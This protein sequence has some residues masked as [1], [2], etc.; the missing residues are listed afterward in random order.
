MTANGNGRF[1]GGDLYDNNMTLFLLD[2]VDSCFDAMDM[3]RFAFCSF[4]QDAAPP[5]WCCV[6]D[7]CVS[8]SHQRVGTTIL[9]TPSR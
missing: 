7:D 2:R 3:K 6:A 4:R 1:C 8:I 9:T 5:W